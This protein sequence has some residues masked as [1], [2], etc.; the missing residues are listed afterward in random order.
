MK[1]HLLFTC[2]I[3][4]GIHLSAQNYLK[5]QVLSSGEKMDLSVSNLLKTNPKSI[6]KI[7][8]YDNNEIAKGIGISGAAYSLGTF[9]ELPKEVLSAYNSKTI[10]YIRFGID[11]TEIISNATIAIYEDNLTGTPIL[12]QNLDTADILKGWNQIKLDNGYTI[13]SKTIFVGVSVETNAGGYTQTYDTDPCSSPQY[14]GHTILN[15]SY[16]GTLS[17]EV[18]IDADYNIQALITDGQGADY[19]DLAVIDIQPTSE[20]CTFSSEEILKVTFLNL[21][22]DSINAEFNLAVTINETNINQQVTPTLFYPNTPK[23]INIPNF[24]MSNLGVYTI[25]GSFDFKDSNPE[26]NEFITTLLSGDAILKI[27]LLT[28]GYPQ[29]TSW[30]L[31]DQNGTLVAKNELLEAETY[32]NTELC[33]VNNN[34]YSWIISDLSENGMNGEGSNPGEFT[35]TYNDTI[36]AQSSGNGNFGKEFT[37]FGIGNGCFTND[38]RITQ[39]ELPTFEVPQTLPIKGTIYNNGTDT[40]TSFDL[41]YKIENYTSPV[42]KISGIEIPIGQTYVFT[43]DVFY[44]FTDEKTYLI[45][46]SV[47]NPN[48]KEDESLVDN[49]FVHK[50][51]INSNVIPKRQLIEH[52]TSST[53]DECFNF[54]PLLDE[55]L[56]SNYDN[57]S[58]IRYQVNWPG[59]GDPY[60]TDQTGNRV[61]YYQVTDIPSLYRNGK[62][63]MDITQEGFDT[64]AGQKTIISIEG[65]AFYT[66]NDVMIQAIVKS[67]SNTESGLKLHATIVENSTFVNIGTN[68][69]TEFYNV[70]MQMLPNAEGTNLNTIIAGNSESIS[71][72][73]DMSA[74]F[75]EETSDLTA[76]IFVQDSATK[77]ILQSSMMP[78]SLADYNKEKIHSSRNLYPNP[79]TNSIIVD[80]LSI[81]SQIILSNYFGKKIVIVTNTMERNIINTENLKSGI[82]LITIIDAFNNTTTQKMVKS[83]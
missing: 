40:L 26:N 14:S 67:V 38:I 60:Y 17:N 31:L 80:G 3:A 76:V 5:K 7:F 66:D 46:V 33:V 52:F 72:T 77:E 2:I 79:F 39:I 19:K 45:E 8:S 24:D 62:F 35:L 43:H 65:S 30:K 57:F 34:C 82:Y 48:N 63:D 16:F 49:F 69:E 58:L 75:V 71:I 44:N 29:E 73:F 23:T 15:G 27:D 61:Q 21:G 10:D 20:G 68:G 51:T 4:S 28:D 74:T 56:S 78:I 22:E 18:G 11:I 12:S 54:T 81:G 50:T 59:T 37:V 13:G 55:M 36:I 83:N 64:Y 47:L 25:H 32:Y 9:I 42:T 41:S 6:L 1:K 70:L 53:N